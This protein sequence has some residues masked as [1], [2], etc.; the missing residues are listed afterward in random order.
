M[1]SIDSSVGKGQ[2]VKKWPD[3]RM[4]CDS[5]SLCSQQPVTGHFYEQMDQV[6]IHPVS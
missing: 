3:N 2:L 1:G 5:L 6:H 4:A